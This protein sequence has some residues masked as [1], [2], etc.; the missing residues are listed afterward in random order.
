M[1][2]P[3]SGPYLCFPVFSPY[4][5]RKHSCWFLP[6]VEPNSNSILPTI[7]CSL[8]LLLQLVLHL[9]ALL[10]L[11]PVSSNQLGFATRAPSQN[12]AISSAMFFWYLFS[13]FCNSHFLGEAF[14]DHDMSNRFPPVMPGYNAFISFE[15]RWN[16]Y[17]HCW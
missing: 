14:Q 16:M 3:Y 10:H 11:T 6:G 9:T 8:A 5:C 17:I 1:D 7:L 4:T 2:S 15:L 12:R 13:W